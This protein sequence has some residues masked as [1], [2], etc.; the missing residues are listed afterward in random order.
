MD[1]PISVPDLQ[2]ILAVIAPELE[3]THTAQNLYTF[4]DWHQHDGYVTQR[5]PT[6]W[7]SLVA[8]SQSTD[9]LIAS[10]HGDT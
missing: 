5:C 9:V 7:G 2:A 4:D 10:R 1:D 3:V 8:V 6:E